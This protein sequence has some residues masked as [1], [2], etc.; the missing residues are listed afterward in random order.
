MSLDRTRKRI[1]DQLLRR[2]PVKRLRHQLLLLQ[3]LHAARLVHVLQIDL[4]VEERH[5]QAAG[6]TNRATVL[7]LV[8]P[9]GV[10]R[11]QRSLTLLIDAAED[12]LHVVREEALVVEDV[13]Q[14]LCAGCTEISLPCWYWY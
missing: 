5:D 4:V 1:A 3:P 6:R 11:V 12:G 14:P 2:L 13:A 9:Y 10:V 8:A 7:P